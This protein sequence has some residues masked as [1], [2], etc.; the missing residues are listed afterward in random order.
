MKSLNCLRVWVAALAV[1]CLPAI[2]AATVT[3]DSA[4]VLVDTRDPL[5]LTVTA[6]SHGGVSGAGLYAPG[7]AVILTPTP[8]AGYVFTGWTGAA[9]GTQNPLTV[10]LA[11]NQEIGATFVPDTRDSD[12]DGLT[13][14]EELT[15]YATNPNLA[16]SDGDGL[17]DGYE[18]GIGRFSIVAVS[19]TWAQARSDAR[20][21]GGELACFPTQVVWNQAIASLGATAL[22]D[23]TGLWVGASDAA[24][25]GTW[26][27]V[28]GTAFSYNAWALNR[29]SAVA[30]NTLDYAEVSGGAGADI[31]KWYDRSPTTTRDGYILEI[32]YTTDPRV[33]DVDGDGL[34]DAQE[35]TAGTNPFV[36]DTDGDGLTDGEEVN[37]TQTN[38][39]LADSNS[40]GIN[41]AAD[42]Q[43]GDGLS[44]LAEIRT[45]LTNPRVADTDGDGLSDGAEVLTHHTNPRVA[46]TD[47]DGFNDGYEVAN[48]SSPTSASSFPTYTLTLSGS[49]VV[50]GGSF[51]KSGTLAHGSTATLTAVAEAGYVFSAWTGDLAGSVNPQTLLM[52]GDKT[53][54]AEFGHDTQ[55]SDGDGLTNYEESVTY[56]TNP[57]LVDTDGDGLTDIAEIQTQ[58]TNPVLKDSNGDGL[59][60]GVA[61][62]MG[63]DPLADHAALVQIIHDSRETFGLYTQQD[64]TDLRPGSTTVKV[65]PSA[66]GVQLRLKVQ[67]SAD[68]QNW[69]DAGEAVYEQ[70]ADPAAPKRFFRFGV[71]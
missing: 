3:V 27:W 58:H 14:F 47:G 64:M 5:N 56:G 25:E 17:S 44:N 16:D 1:F 10:T 15:I 6:S 53:V 23:Y 43:D 30:G 54:G 71:E 28:N 61:V 31:G 66:G 12:G 55:D 68:L 69:Q 32:G 4:N 24:T 22:D 20:T 21:R 52:N 40:N 57:S 48:A 11:S 9:T 35:Q 2:H 13:N 7:S 37:L 38:P 29:P 41:D 39:K 49:G 45:Q 18:A 36:A 26:K 70:A 34:N 59:A 19:S 60:D 62:Q 33:A 46:D 63:L 42:D 67:Q 50:T 8:S 51:S 65:L